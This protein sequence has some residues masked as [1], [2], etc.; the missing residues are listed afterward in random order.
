MDCLCEHCKKE[1]D[2]SYGSGRFCSKECA[3]GFS[4]AAKRQEIN[5]KLSLKRR[6]IKIEK[7]CVECGST[8]LAKRTNQICCGTECASKR[9]HKRLSERAR[10]TR[11]AL[12]G[13]GRG[14]YVRKPTSILELSGRTI[15]KILQRC[16]IAKCS[17]CGWDKCNCD[18]HHLRGKRIE[19]PN[20]H[21]NLTYVCPNCHR[22]IHRGQIPFSQIP[23]LDKLLP[24]NWT[25][26]Y[27][28]NR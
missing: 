18:M 2:G 26:Y 28:G 15:V 1:H 19:N 21:D 5:L 11:I 3:R 23:T 8:F 12:G 14:N 17:I 6:K 16:N 25:D 9:R 24:L 10:L 20:S 7:E 4:T 27:F 13:S 22:M